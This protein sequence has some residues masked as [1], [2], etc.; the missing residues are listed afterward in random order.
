MN[1]ARLDV[2]HP[3][4]NLSLRLDERMLLQVLHVLLYRFFQIAI[5]N[6]MKVNFVHRIRYSFVSGVVLLDLL[7]KSI[8]GVMAQPTVSVV[9]YCNVTDKDF[10]RDDNVTQRFFAG[11]CSL[12]LDDIEKENDIPT[13]ARIPGNDSVWKHRV[14][15]RATKRCTH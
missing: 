13:A 10:L 4:S 6:V 14:H 3:A 8:R 9:N 5:L 15:K 12:V 7:A 1:L 11:K 2:I